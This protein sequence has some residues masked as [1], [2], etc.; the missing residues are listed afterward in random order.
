MTMNPFQAGDSVQCWM[1]LYGLL[2][3]QQ[4]AMPTTP[5]LMLLVVW[6]LLG[7]VSITASQP[8]TFQQRDGTTG[9]LSPLDEQHAVYGMVAEETEI[10]I[11][12]KF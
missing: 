5:T 6:I 11:K 9:T 4:D 8:S 1:C 7:P 2:R 12:N 3:T 10:E